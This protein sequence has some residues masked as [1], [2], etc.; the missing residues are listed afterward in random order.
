MERF[1]GHRRRSGIYPVIRQR[2]RMEMRSE[3][4]G[5]TMM[6][7]NDLRR[8]GATRLSPRG[9]ARGPRA[10]ARARV[11]VPQGGGGRV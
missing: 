7:L 8:M 10:R 1:Q 2:P 9:S 3:V 11:T 6:R 5:I 4:R